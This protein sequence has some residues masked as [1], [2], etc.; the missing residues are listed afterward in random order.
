MKLVARFDFGVA[1]TTTG[2]S[3]AATVDIDCRVPLG[4]TVFRATD[5]DVRQSSTAS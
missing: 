3:S 5:G 2:L 4:V 1:C